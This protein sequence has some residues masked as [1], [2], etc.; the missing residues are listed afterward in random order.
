MCGEDIAE[1]V[2]RSSLESRVAFCVT[3]EEETEVLVG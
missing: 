3:M 2:E 1:D